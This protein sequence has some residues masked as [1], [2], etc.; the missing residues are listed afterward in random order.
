ME[1]LR[2]AVDE[3]DLVVVFDYENMRTN[4]FKEVRRD[5][6]SSRFFLGK[7]KVMQVALGKT[8][9]DEY[10]PGLSKLA[11]HIKGQ[12]GLLL[13]NKSLSDVIKS[14]DS[15]RRKDYARSGAIATE[16]VKLKEGVLHGQEASKVE[17]FK[18]LGMPVKVQQAQPYLMESF[19]VCKKGN[20]LTPEQCAILKQMGLEMADFKMRVICSWSNG[21]F[22]DQKQ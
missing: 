18:T 3:Y 21:K 4:H 10:R 2:D 1:S 14:F 22:V 16:T 20:V 12:C 8:Q 15:F 9:E 17:Y 11:K 5:W 13:T 6:K 7:N 19:T